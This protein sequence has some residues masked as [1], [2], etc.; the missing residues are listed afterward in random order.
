MLSRANV[1][2]ALELACF[3]AISGGVAVAG[4]ALAGPMG[5]VASGLIA[6]GAAGVYLVNVYSMPTP[7]E[8]PPDD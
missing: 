5:G 8:E 1:L 7:E 4:W 3:A 6:G 2:A